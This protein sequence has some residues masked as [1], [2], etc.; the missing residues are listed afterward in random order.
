MPDF[1]TGLAAAA[2]FC[3]GILIFNGLTRLALQLNVAPLDLAENGFV[4]YGLALALS[5]ALWRRHARA[6]RC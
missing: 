1:I 3:A 6:P 4:Q 2:L 5:G